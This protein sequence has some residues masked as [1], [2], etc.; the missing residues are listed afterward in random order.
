M[1]LKQPEEYTK[2]IDFINRMI[3]KARSLRPF[4]GDK[5]SNRLELSII[6][7]KILR[8]YYTIELEMA[9][10]LHSRGLCRDGAYTIPEDMHEMMVRSAHTKEAIEASIERL[11]RKE[12]K[13]ESHSTQEFRYYY[14]NSEA[15]WAG[16]INFI[17]DELGFSEDD[18]DDGCG[19]NS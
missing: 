11:L 5:R 15:V 19:S 6:N 1:A 10:Y 14:E 12:F 18:T 7:L 17:E 3:T 4:T 2:K 9:E 8:D 16:Y 13:P